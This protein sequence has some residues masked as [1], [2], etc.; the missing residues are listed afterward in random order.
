MKAAGRGQESTGAV[1]T[2]DAMDPGVLRGEGIW[3]SPLLCP[4]ACWQHQLGL[5][6]KPFLNSALS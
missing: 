4:S 1:T 6:L 5:S 2:S 3:K